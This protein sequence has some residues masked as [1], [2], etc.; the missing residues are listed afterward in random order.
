MLRS[1][2]VGK[3]SVMA[4]TKELKYDKIYISS[5]PHMLTMHKKRL[6]LLHHYDIE[7]EAFLSYITSS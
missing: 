3:G 4:I 5:V 1:M 7:G 2:S 6:N